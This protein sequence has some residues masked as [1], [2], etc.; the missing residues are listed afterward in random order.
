MSNPFHGLINYTLSRVM[1]IIVLYITWKG[2]VTNNTNR[3]IRQGFRL[4]ITGENIEILSMLERKSRD[5]DGARQVLSPTMTTL[6][7]MIE[8]ETFPRRYGEP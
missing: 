4:I 3:L 2:L 1:E 6:S 5:G 7:F 8:G